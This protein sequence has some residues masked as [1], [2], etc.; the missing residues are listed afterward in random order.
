LDSWNCVIIAALLVGPG[1]VVAQSRGPALPDGAVR[2][3]GESRLRQGETVL[4][5]SFS[6]DGK[7][8]VSGGGH[9]DPTIR[10]WDV[11]TGHEVLRIASGQLSVSDVKFVSNGRLIASGGGGEFALRLW[12]AEDGKLVR[13]F[14]QD[15]KWAKVHRLDGSPRTN[16]IVTGNS[17]ATISFWNT[18]T[19]HET[20]SLDVRGDSAPDVRFSPNKNALLSWGSVSLKIRMWDLTKGERAYILEQDDFT[21][22]PC[23]SP[24]GETFVTGCADGSV[25]WFESTSGKEIGSATGHAEKV[26][27]VDFSP[28]GASVVSS[29]ADGSIRFWDSTTREELRRIEGLKRTP[30]AIVSPDG[31]RI[32][33]R[34]QNSSVI[35]LWDAQTLEP[36]VGASEDDRP[37]TSVAFQA[38][39]RSVV[40]VQP[41][42][43]ESWSVT[44]SDS[45]I[46]LESDNDLVG[47]RPTAD[48]AFVVRR[49]RGLKPGVYETK[50][51]R[52]SAA[53]REVKL[54]YRGMDGGGLLAPDGSAVALW[55]YKTP[56]RLRD[57]AAET[58]VVVSESAPR[59]RM[60]A[61]YSLDGRHLGLVEGMQARVVKTT[62]EPVASLSIPFERVQALAL[63]ADART[64]AIVQRWTTGHGTADIT[65][66]DV[67]SGQV[68]RRLSG[69]GGE[70]KA[71]TF[72]DDGRRL[73][74]ISRDRTTRVW[75]LA[76]GDEI[77]RFV[78]DGSTPVCVAFS[79]D[80]KL[81]ATGISGGGGWLWKVP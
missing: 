9:R 6:P 58:E 26:K 8:L 27:A 53:D 43:L 14:S 68:V 50:V 10:V 34:F 54:L 51:C 73:A 69:H 31:K 3:F 52:I 61:A 55:S 45:A 22:P 20:Q 66:L 32:A 40:T 64:I 70:I 46:V 28:D 19:G 81:V 24:D 33:A 23:F 21:A 60:H 56:I 18:E 5:L 11:A 42:R 74:S 72:S 71:I 63:S 49:V 12:N 78:D 35:R 47:V 41:D 30:Y 44:S 65:L 4:G 39:D 38:G 25:R 36:L 7:R 13:Q 37:W 1:L 59:R 2:R 57:L 77:A 29:S 79:H 16:Q 48:I 17:N 75:N 67:A 62:G 15:P 80:G 76:T